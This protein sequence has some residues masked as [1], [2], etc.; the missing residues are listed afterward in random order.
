LTERFTFNG[1]YML[2]K[3]IS[4]PSHLMVLGF[5]IEDLSQS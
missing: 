1:V 5:S 4:C 2:D 3:F